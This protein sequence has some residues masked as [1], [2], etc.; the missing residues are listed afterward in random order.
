VNAA[1]RLAWAQIAAR[2]GT[3]PGI[4][5]ADKTLEGVTCL[6]LDATVVACHSD[7]QGAEPNFKGLCDV[8][9]L[10]VSERVEGGQ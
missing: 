5:I 10:V 2:H 4:R 9:P 3:L 7:K 1:R 8:M 6:R